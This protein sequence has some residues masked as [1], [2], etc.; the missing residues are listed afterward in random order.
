MTPILMPIRD[1]FATYALKSL[2]DCI[3]TE[4]EREREKG[5]ILD[6]KTRDTS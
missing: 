1:K 4:R 2:L 6:D 5:K 3:K